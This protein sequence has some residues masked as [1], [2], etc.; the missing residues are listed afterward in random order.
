MDAPPESCRLC[1]RSH[2]LRDSHI[3]PSFVVKLIKGGPS[4]RLRFAESPDVPAQDGI[5]G[6]L[7]CPGCEQVLSRKERAVADFVRQCHLGEP[8]YLYGPD[9]APFVLG[10]A[11]RVLAWEVQ[12]GNETDWIPRVVRAA[13]EAEATWRNA[14]L[15]DNFESVSGALHAFILDSSG[16]PSENMRRELP[17]NWNRYLDVA[18]DSTV[19]SSMDPATPGGAAVAMVYAKLGKLVTL[20]FIKMPNERRWKGTRIHREGELNLGSIQLPESFLR[21][22]AERAGQT[23]ERLRAMSN[24]Q[25]ERIGDRVVAAVGRGE[26]VPAL[27]SLSRDIE[28]FGHEEVFRGR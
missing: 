25:R 1:R 10:V 21:F 23:N 13:R 11:W 9:F 5:H 8:P 3:V 18:I 28:M 24:R 20:A 17:S 12:R 27:D 22:M 19:A 2:D 16:T 4:G 15:S 6:K 7:L 14:L 26:S